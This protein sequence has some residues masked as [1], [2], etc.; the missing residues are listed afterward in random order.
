MKNLN[1]LID[2]TNNVEEKAFEYSKEH[3]HLLDGTPVIDPQIVR[4]IVYGANMMHSNLA[5][6]LKEAIG[7][8]ATMDE[9]LAVRQ[10]RRKIRSILEG[11]GK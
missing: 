5:P 1:E 3:Y 8:I 6:A 7:L 10:T 9:S 4:A 2:D 11:R